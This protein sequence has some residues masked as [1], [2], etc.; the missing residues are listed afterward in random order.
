MRSNIENLVNLAKKNNTKL[1]LVDDVVPFGKNY[2]ADFFPKFT[3]YRDGPSISRSKAEAIRS[4]YT[5]VLKK[6]IDNKT[7]YYIDPLPKV[8][9]NKYCKA[10]IDGKLIYADGSPH[11]NKEGSL[12]LQNLWLEE[13][14]K[15][16]N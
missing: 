5:N 12:I 7:T 15:I 14:P 10:V 11:F 9:G 6:Y 13:L 4:E 8:C 3:F 16:L 2:D 1:I